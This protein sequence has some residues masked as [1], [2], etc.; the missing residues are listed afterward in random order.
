MRPTVRISQQAVGEPTS[1]KGSSF[2]QIRKEVKS[3]HNEG[4]GRKYFPELLFG[5]AQIPTFVVCL[6]S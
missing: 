2:C 1:R 3:L 4:K 6:E 5:Y